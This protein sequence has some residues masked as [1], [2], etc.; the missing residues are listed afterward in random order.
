MRRH[1][2]LTGHI[3]TPRLVCIHEATFNRLGAA[4]RDA[5]REVVAAEARAQ[6]EQ[7]A[8]QERE[9]LGT[10]RNGGMNVIE[11]DLES[12]RRPVIVALPPRF[13]SR[14]GRGM[15]ERIQAI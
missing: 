2:V 12:F 1:L 8:G 9:L 13:E 14:W 6:D 7:L 11:P 10:L 3:I 15:W 5:L 4:D